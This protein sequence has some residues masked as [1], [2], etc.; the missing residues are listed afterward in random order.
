MTKTSLHKKWTRKNMQI[1]LP[2]YA[3]NSTGN[4]N[5]EKDMK[6]VTKNYQ[7]VT[8]CKQ[9]NAPTKEVSLKNK[10]S[11]PENLERIKCKV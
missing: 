3:V 11:A 7:H 5:I 2:T 4:N 10:K 9:T 1:L 8:R 6:S